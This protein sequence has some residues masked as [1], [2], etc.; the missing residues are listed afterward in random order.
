EHADVHAHRIGGEHD[1]EHVLYEDQ[2]TQR[3][4]EQTGAIRAAALELL[5]QQQIDQQTGKGSGQNRAEHS[6]SQREMQ[7]LLTDVRKIRREREYRAM[8][9]VKV[10]RRSIDEP[11]SDCLLRVE[12]A[13]HQTG[14]EQ[15]QE[16]IHEDPIGLS[17]AAQATPCRRQRCARGFHQCAALTSFSA[18]TLPSFSTPTSISMTAA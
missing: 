6:D 2:Q 15:L 16:K 14:S 9:Y 12:A 18:S 10:E 7:E 5:I 1:G 13:A 11:P 8:R 17:T 4:N 3:G